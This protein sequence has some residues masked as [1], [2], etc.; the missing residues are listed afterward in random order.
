MTDA[1]PARLIPDLKRFAIGFVVGAMIVYVN[2]V[3]TS[4]KF[5]I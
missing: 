1:L 4:A 3:E 2:H 5:M